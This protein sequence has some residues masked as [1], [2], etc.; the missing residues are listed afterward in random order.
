M[1]LSKLAPW[2][3][4]IF[5]VAALV[6]A[7]LIARLRHERYDW[8]QSMASIGVA[9]VQRL[10]N[11]AAGGLVL[12]TLIKVWEHRLWTI[13]LDAWWDYLLLFV[14]VEFTY[15]WHHRCSHEC[16]WFW[17]THSVHHSP[18]KMYLSGAVRL[19]WTGQISGAFLFYAPLVWLGFSPIAVLMMLLANLVYQFW[20]HTE[21]IGSLGNFDRVFNSPSNHRVHHAVNPIY[22]DRNYGGVIMLFDHVF[23]T[24]QRELAANPPRYGLVKQI[25][26]HNPFRIALNEWWQ[27]TK[28]L[29][30]SASFK[31]ALGYLFAAPGWRPDGFGMTSSRIRA[32]AQ[33]ARPATSA[34]SAPPRT[35]HQ[36]NPAR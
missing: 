13:P 27:I 4:G 8:R 36:T 35:E 33:P 12:A 20:L 14:A 29:R 16:R 3:F 18:Q 5:A 25:E 30:A 31:Q 32:L 22:L 23:G 26:S 6:E 9:I 34:A 24:Y 7:I 15:Y 19:G 11:V 17:A 10:V 2:V 28:D 21:L 1:E